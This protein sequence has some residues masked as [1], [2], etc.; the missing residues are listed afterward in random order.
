VSLVTL[1]PVVVLLV[2]TVC[3]GIALGR[4]LDEAQQLKME[5]E[6]ARRL[7]PLVAQVS[8]ESQRLR[9][10]LARLQRRP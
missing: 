5:L 4:L 10:V 7:Q 9:L 6:R 2:G 8:T 1:L 3:A